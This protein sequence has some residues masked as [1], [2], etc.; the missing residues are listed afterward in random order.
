MIDST[1]RVR[2]TAVLAVYSYDK[3][4]LSRA[5]ACAKKYIIF[6]RTICKNYSG[7]PISGND[8]CAASDERDQLSLHPCRCWGVYHS[9]GTS[10]QRE[11]DI[12]VDV[13]L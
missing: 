7:W 11:Y 3:E 12:A 5:Q 2:K 8:Q 1:D 9:V 6:R 10:C 4:M 13:I